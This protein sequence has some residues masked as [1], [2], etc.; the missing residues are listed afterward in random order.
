MTRFVWS[1]CLIV[2]EAFGLV[3]DLVY[4]GLVVILILLKASLL[5]NGKSSDE[6]YIHGGLKQGDTLSLFF[7]FLLWMLCIYPFVKQL[8]EEVFKGIQLQDLWLYLI[9]FM[10]DAFFFMVNG[11]T[12]LENKFRYPLGY[13]GGGDGSSYGL[14]DVVLKLQSRLSKLESENPLV[15]GGVKGIRFDSHSVRKVSLWS[16]ILK[17]VQVLKYLDLFLVVLS[18][19]YRGRSIYSF[20]MGKETWIGVPGYVP[21]RD[22]LEDGGFDEQQEFSD[23]SSFLNSVVLSTYNDRWRF[24]IVF[25]VGGR[26]ISSFGVR[27]KIGEAVV[28]FYSFFGFSLEVFWKESSSLLG[29]FL[30]ISESSPKFDVNKTSRSSFF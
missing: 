2:L 4:L 28:L 3:L 1:S 7:L 19:L 8:M 23:L 27:S 22:Q 14:G 6:S 5:V 15:G 16:S 11:C 12:I 21:F 17:E 13:G 24:C 30:G 20:G 10:G 18:K 26:S 25:A 9:Y 29:G